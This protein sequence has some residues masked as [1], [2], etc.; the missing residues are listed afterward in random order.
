MTTLFITLFAVLIGIVPGFLV[1]IVRSTCIKT[2]RLKILDFFCRIYL[3]VIR[4]TPV[5]VQ[6]LITYFVI[7]GNGIKS[8]KSQT[9]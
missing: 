4:G 5:V 6:L 9:Q 7:Y 1:A 8:D 3:T 2:G